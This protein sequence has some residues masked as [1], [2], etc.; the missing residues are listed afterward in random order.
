[1]KKTLSFNDFCDEMN[2]YETAKD[3][4]SYDGKKALYDYLTEIETEQEN[5]I[6]LDVVA[7]CC[8]YNEYENLEEFHKDYDKEQYPDI[9]TIQEN[10]TVIKVND[11]AFIIQQF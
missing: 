7:L 10:T 8:E 5:E 6:E 9:E 4:F 3:K 2:G 11:E 1:M